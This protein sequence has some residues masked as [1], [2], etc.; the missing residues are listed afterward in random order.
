MCCI[1]LC[2]FTPFSLFLLSDPLQS[3]LND[4]PQKLRDST[5]SLWAFEIG[6]PVRG[7]TISQSPQQMERMWLLWELH[8]GSSQQRHVNEA[9]IVTSIGVVSL[10]IQSLDNRLS[11]L[12][13]ISQNLG[14]R[15][16]NYQLRS[17]MSWR[18]IGFMYS[19]KVVSSIQIAVER[20]NEHF[21]ELDEL[22]KMN[23]K[24]VSVK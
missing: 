8:G 15:I 9:D 2:S 10:D 17:E 24:N 11:E 16:D 7:I 3:N 6:F 21:S 5:H 18:C 23:C 19:R 20:M 22:T 14:T 13:R 1:H 12:T 4:C